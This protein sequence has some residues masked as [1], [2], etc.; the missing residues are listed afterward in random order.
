MG[1]FDLTDGPCPITHDVIIRS[2]A[3]FFLILGITPLE[4]ICSL[5]HSDFFMSFL[6]K[7]IRMVWES[8]AQYIG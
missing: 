7:R 6:I 8:S 4:Q 2:P 3:A 5:R 1:L